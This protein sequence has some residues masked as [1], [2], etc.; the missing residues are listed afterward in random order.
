MSLDYNRQ[1]LNKLDQ[2]LQFQHLQL[3]MVLL[4]WC[5][6]LSLSH[7]CIAF[8]RLTLYDLMLLNLNDTGTV[9]DVILSIPWRDMK[10]VVNYFVSSKG[11][12][13]LYALLGF[14]KGILPDWYPS[15]AILATL[16]NA[17]LIDRQRVLAQLLRKTADTGS[18][19][20][21]LRKPLF[22]DPFLVALWA[23]YTKVEDK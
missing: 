15:G 12:L 9:S 18:D 11:D 8:D 17:K 19:G 2:H 1:L 7:H 5:E 3:Y 16:Q 14:K 6:L 21:A 20:G 10:V 23:A 13:N 4:F 22:N